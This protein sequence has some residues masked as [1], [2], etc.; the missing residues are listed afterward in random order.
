MI[1]LES[2]WG[3]KS[4]QSG[5]SFRWGSRLWALEEHLAPRAQAWGD[6]PPCRWTPVTFPGGERHW[7]KAKRG[8][9]LTLWMEH[10][11]TVCDAAGPFSSTIHVSQPVSQAASGFGGIGR[12]EARKPPP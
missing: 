12:S 1:C 3:L 11:V 4:I 7:F 10:T 9:S 8:L 6:P 5:S 2:V